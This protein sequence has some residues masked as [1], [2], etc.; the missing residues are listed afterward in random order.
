MEFKDYYKILGVER[1]A[2]GDAIKKAFRKLA[3]KHHPD[4]NPGNKAAEER[5]KEINEANEVLGDAEKRAQYDQL[6]SAWNQAGGPGQA[7]FDWED[8]L[9]RQG[10]RGRTRA[11]SAGAAGESMGDFS[12]FFSSF[13][14]GGMR[15]SPGGFGGP[16][17]PRK[18]DD[19]HADLEI[20]LEDAYHGVKK[21]FDLNGRKVNLALKPGI[22]DGKTIL[23]RGKGGVAPRGGVEGDLTLRI[24]ILPHEFWERRGD[25]LYHVEDLDALSAIAGCQVEIHTMK[26]S[27]KLTV[28]PMTDSG[29]VLRLRGQGMPLHDHPGSWGDL[30]VTLRLVL[31]K[32][33]TAQEMNQLKALA[34][35]REQER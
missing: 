32:H 34:A 11:Q 1:N 7:D 16:A 4:K 35:G 19:Y 33:L 25:D 2:S 20:S 14:G 26:G 27:V 29:K 9:R 13:F 23:L 15:G 30:Y 8:L 5:F 31:P 22:A 17:G 10:G 28:P 21:T 24:H 6:G 18:G 3:G 12:D